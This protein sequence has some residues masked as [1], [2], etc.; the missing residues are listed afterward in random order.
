MK[1]IDEKTF[2]YI[3]N[4][5]R[6]NDGLSPCYRD[7]QQATGISSTSMVKLSLDRLA[8][9]GKIEVV[10]GKSG[11]IKVIGGRWAMADEL[12][13]TYEIEEANYD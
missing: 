13:P 10:T 9:A 5:K 1:P 12:R 3:L 6:R 8:E 2:L 7:I 4:Y 11:G